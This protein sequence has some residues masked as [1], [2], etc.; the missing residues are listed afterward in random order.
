LIAR[1]DAAAQ[2]QPAQAEKPKPEKP[3]KKKDDRQASLF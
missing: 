1:V 2:V 3:A